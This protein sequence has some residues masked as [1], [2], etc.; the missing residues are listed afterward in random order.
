MSP[1]FICLVGLI[2]TT[3]EFRGKQSQLLLELERDSPKL[4]VWAAK[5]TIGLSGPFFFRSEAGNTT[6]VTGEN[7]LKML[8]EFAVPELQAK[9]DI[10]D[11]VF[12]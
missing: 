6:N 9:T 7:N 5:S 4:L 3:A 2:D 12:Q 1:S 11:V 8:Q 10:N